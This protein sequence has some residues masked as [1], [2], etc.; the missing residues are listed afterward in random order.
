MVTYPEIGHT[1]NELDRWI[2]HVVLI[3]DGE[4]LFVVDQVGQVMIR[5][6]VAVHRAMMWDA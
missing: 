2:K 1:S 6:Y 4:N 3:L 5:A